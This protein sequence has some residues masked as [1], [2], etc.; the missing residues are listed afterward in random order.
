MTIQLAE[1]TVGDTG[2]CPEVKFFYPIKFLFTPIIKTSK[3]SLTMKE[4]RDRISELPERCSKLIES[5]GKAIKSAL[6]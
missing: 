4:I 2:Q 3:M 1:C 5:I 6:W